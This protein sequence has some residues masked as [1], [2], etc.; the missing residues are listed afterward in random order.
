ARLSVGGYH[1][2][3][4]ID[5]QAQD[6]AVTAE[7]DQGGHYV[8]SGVDKGRESALV[9]VQPGDGAIRAMYGG[10]EFCRHKHKDDC[11]DL[12]G[13]A[14]NYARPSGS[15]FKPYTLIAAL[16]NGIGLNSTFAG[17]P[18]IDFPG[19]N[20]KGISNSELESCGVC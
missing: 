6:A 20:G 3:T 15:S 8:G 1:V 14:S 16:K 5:K 2:V 4:T 11:T 10:N 19:T 17:P 12:T 18:H 7:K 13:V 9:S